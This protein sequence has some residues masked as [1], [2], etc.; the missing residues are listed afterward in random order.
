MPWIGVVVGIPE[1][2][3]IPGLIPGPRAFGF[4]FRVNALWP[5]SQLTPRSIIGTAQVPHGASRATPTPVA[6][7]TSG[8]QLSGSQASGRH[9]SRVQKMV[10][11]HETNPESVLHVSLALQS[12]SFLHG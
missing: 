6:I 9:T 4:A 11:S 2:T 10:W 1:L 8:Q 12:L 7:L 3:L 5:G